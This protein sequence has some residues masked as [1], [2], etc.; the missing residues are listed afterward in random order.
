MSDILQPNNIYHGDARE[1]L[2][3][4]EPNSI[5][6]SIWSPP[7]FVGKSYEKYLKSYAEWRE[8]LEEVVRLHYPII[9]PGGFVVINIADILCFADPKMPRF[10]AETMSQRRSPV[11]REDVL[12]ARAKFPTYNRDQLAAF[13]GCSE[14]TVD[15]R[16]NGNNIRGGKYATQTRVKLVAGAVE[17]WARKAGFYVYDR[18]A[19]VKDPAWQNCDWHSSSYR[20]VDEF[21]YLYFLWKPGAS[22]VD[23]QR[24]SSREWAEWGSRGV[25]FIR[26]VRNN[27]DHEAKF[28][29]ELPKRLIRMLS[30][31]GE[32][33][34]DCFM[35]SGSTAVAA[36][37]VGRRYIGIDRLAKYVQMAQ[38]A[39]QLA[40]LSNGMALPDQEES[41]EP[42]MLPLFADAAS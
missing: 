4:I 21:E 37:Q 27:G 19:W 26:S 18:R 11:T 41:L 3:R 16:L 2:P 34:L 14:Q 6:C 5:A 15:R 40:T 23:R 24:L 39:C 8:M 29:V 36:I 17:K 1:L 38:D 30:A 10:Q 13:L 42:A 25:W 33:V 22:T 12:A 7:Y 20:S 31:P 28:P 35:G 32:T 9:R